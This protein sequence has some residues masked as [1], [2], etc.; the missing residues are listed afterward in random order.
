MDLQDSPRSH[1][2]SHHPVEV[3][4]AAEDSQLEFADQLPAAARPVGHH[5]EE[6]APH[7]DD[8]DLWRT[9][10]LRSEPIVKKDVAISSLLG[11]L[12]FLLL[13]VF[14]FATFK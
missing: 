1:R 4:L 11:S 10:L 2:R 5:Q 6:E 14:Y 3:N 7:P 8:S 9:I 13:L 12:I